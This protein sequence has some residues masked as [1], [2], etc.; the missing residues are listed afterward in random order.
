VLTDVVAAGTKAL[1][2]ARFS[3]VSILPGTLF[4]SIVAMAALSG[5]YTSDDPGLA[6]LQEAVK[7]WDTAGAVLGVLVLFLT[8]VLLQPFQV[9]LVQVLEGYWQRR[10]L[11]ALSSVAIERHRRRMRTAQVERRSSVPPAPAATDLRAGA[12]LTRARALVARRRTR[13]DAV[14]RR[15]PVKIEKVLPTTLG[16]IL[17]N[18]EEAAGDRYGLEA[19]TLY[20]RMYP[21]VSKP[22][23]DAMAR[24][25][26]TIS[27]T[28]SLTVSSAAAAVATAPLAVRQLGTFWALVP[29]FAL[30]LA[31]VS[32]RGSLRAAADHGL[33]FATTFD[34]HRF[35]MIRAL[36][37]ALPSTFAEERALY[38]ELKGFYQ[39]RR[40]P[41]PPLER[42]RFD[43]SIY[44]QPPPPPAPE[45][46]GGGGNGGGAGPE[47]GSADSA[48]SG[49]NRQDSGDPAGTTTAAEPGA[50]G[51]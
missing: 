13:A 18:G 42:R 48:D 32:Y 25:L 40:H 44:D 29:L 20:P 51:A 50:G 39:G 23:M 26:D 14:L 28:A 21:L 4:A 6:K 36:H 38:E 2:G 49:D 12:D 5:A 1:G 24:Q 19:L 47:D 31:V 37:F 22:L 30:L 3:L 17:R 34:L 8:G 16:N 43:H 27:L 11:R 9:A 7:T 46:A 15:Y 33:L 45:Q 10:P 35:D 41:L